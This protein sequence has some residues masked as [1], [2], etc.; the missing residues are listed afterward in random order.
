MS[1]AGIYNYHP[2]VSNPNKIL[3]QMKSIQQQPSFFLGGS[4][5][6]LT[7]GI[8]HEMFTDHPHHTT[9]SKMMGMGVSKKA[10]HTTH[11]LYTKIMLPK[12]FRRV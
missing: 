2:K 4:Q 3:P 11:E 1:T 8:E 6:P 7:L 10:Q 9:N 5:V 12:N